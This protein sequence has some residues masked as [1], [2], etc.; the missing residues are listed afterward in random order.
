[1]CVC[2]CVCVR[3]CDI[4]AESAYA[5]A[6]Q[7]NLFTHR[8]SVH[9]RDGGRVKEIKRA[10]KQASERARVRGA[11]CER[12]GKKAKSECDGKR[13]RETKRE[14]FC[15]CKSEHARAY[16]CVR[17]TERKREKER[18]R[19]REESEWGGRGQGQLENERV[20][21]CVRK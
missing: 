21:F 18:E 11:M 14:K 12:N 1:M 19:K 7:T 8:E 16:V 10:S 15:V 4:H 5:R 3:L 2:V 17:E 6:T 9:G 13:T 20:Y